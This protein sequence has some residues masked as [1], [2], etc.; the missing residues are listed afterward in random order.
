MANLVSMNTRAMNLQTF[1]ENNLAISA[2]TRRFCWQSS[3]L[4]YR[5]AL[6]AVGSR[7]KG[8]TSILEVTDSNL[9]RKIDHIHLDI[10]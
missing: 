8:L 3:K 2:A 10:S 7:D 9:G 6:Q 1:L 5:W 4:Q